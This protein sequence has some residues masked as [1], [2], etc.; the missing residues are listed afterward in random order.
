MDLKKKDFVKVLADKVGATQKDTKVF[1]DEAIET[2]YE[3]LEAGGTLSIDGLGVI[4]TKNKPSRMG[5]NPATGEAIE[6]EAKTAPHFKW[7]SVAKRRAN[8]E[9]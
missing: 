3:I 7:G 4:S 1:V 5:V 2:I 9:E 6:I 8:H